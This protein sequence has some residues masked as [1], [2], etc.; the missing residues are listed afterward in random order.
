MASVPLAGSLKLQTRCKSDM[1][2]EMGHRRQKPIS[3][4]TSNV[5]FQES[6]DLTIANVHNLEHLWFFPL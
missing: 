5:K 2:S 1:Y 3:R 6:T 4:P